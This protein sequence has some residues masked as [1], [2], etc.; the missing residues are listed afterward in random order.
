MSRAG[1]VWGVV[2]ALALAW[3]YRDL[4]GS[5]FLRDDFMWLYD[6]RFQ[7]EEPIRFLTTR[8]SGYFRPFANIVFGFEHMLFGLDPRGFFVFN[9]LLHGWSAFWLA[10]LVRLFGGS[11]AFAGASALTAI[12]LTAAAPGVVWIS[13]LVS[14]LGVAMVL[15]ALYFY[16]RFQI[17]RGAALGE[18]R[19]NPWGDY[20]AALV[21]TVCAVCSRESGVLAGVGIVVLEGVA[22]VGHWRMRA[23]SGGGSALWLRGFALRM[24]PFALAGGLYLWAQWD[25]L[26]GGASV[27]GV[28][29]SPVSFLKHVVI[30]L[31]AMLRAEEWRRGF[32]GPT[33]ALALAGL[34]ALLGLLRGRRG[35]GLGLWLCALF[36]LA[37]LPTYPLLKVDFV[38]ANRYRYEAVFALA[39]MVGALVEALG[40]SRRGPHAEGAPAWRRAA[41]L[42]PLAA[43]VAWHLAALPRFVREDERFAR[44]ADATRAFHGELEAHF[45]QGLIGAQTLSLFGQLKAPR[46]IALVGVPVENPRHLRDHLSV[47]FDFPQELVEEVTFELD[48]PATASGLRARQAGYVKEVCAA[49]EV[50][51]W[52]SDDTLA[53]GAPVSAAMNKDWRRPGKPATRSKV[54]VLVFPQP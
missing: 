9:V 23:A 7:L 40:G 43:L 21:F 45:G 25:F 36:A 15:P 27:R 18:A 51:V 4:P 47:F 19:G 11:V 33:G 39:L 46:R 37:F 1:L 53:R 50:W 30:T 13:G 3:G 28:G 38:M 48:E 26:T 22:F 52:Q 16:R 17:G 6:S 14:L 54:Q 5:W 10:K 24:L 31:P 2:C 32:D 20:V 44:Y 49:D 34:V 12:A 29:G 35:V 41:A 42:V 8:P